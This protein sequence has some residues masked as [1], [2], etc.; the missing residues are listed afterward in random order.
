MEYVLFLKKYYRFLS[1]HW[2]PSCSI[3]SIIAL[4]TR[5]NSFV[6]VLINM[7]CELKNTSWFEKNCFMMIRHCVKEL[8]A[9]NSVT[10]P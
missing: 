1:K 5:V 6:E 3:E 2:Q 8:L 10:R 4:F 9:K 7:V